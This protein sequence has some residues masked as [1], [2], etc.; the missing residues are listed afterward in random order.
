MLGGRD[1]YL[2]KDVG[3]AKGGCAVEEVSLNLLCISEPA[4]FF[5]R[6]L[7]LW[8]SMGKRTS[9]LLRKC[10]QPQQHLVVKQEDGAHAQAQNEVEQQD[11]EDE[12][13]DEE[14]GIPFGDENVKLPAHAKWTK[15]FFAAEA[16]LT[17]RGRGIP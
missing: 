13:E 9:P 1:A 4:Q 17:V 15:D 12:Q 2:Q 16:G 14:H 11:A 6:T 3:S 10:A 8:L 5:C 7:S